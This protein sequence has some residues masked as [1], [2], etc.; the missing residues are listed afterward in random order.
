MRPGK[1][2]QLQ[3]SVPTWLYEKLKELAEKENRSLSNFVSTIL[4]KYIKANEK[5]IRTISA[6][7]KGDKA[8]AQF[9]RQVRGEQITR[10]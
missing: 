8:S 9:E 7:N 10:H 1:T 5:P 4:I 6:P 3:V 2:K